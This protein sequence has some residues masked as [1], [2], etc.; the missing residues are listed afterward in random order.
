MLHSIS[1]RLLAALLLCTVNDRC[2]GSYITG[3]PSVERMRVTA[4]LATLPVGATTPI[5]G[6][7]YDCDGRPIQHRRR[8]AMFLVRDTAVA[9][10]VGNGSA[11]L[12]ARAV[13]ET[14]IVGESGGRRDSV[15]IAVTP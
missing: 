14:W 5:V 1:A 4:A 2:A 8:M 10:V 7:A 6:E 15:R 13:G 9:T 3:V 12:T 11:V